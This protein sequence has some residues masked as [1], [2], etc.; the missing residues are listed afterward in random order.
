VKATSCKSRWGR[1][2]P[3]EPALIP[4]SV[5]V[6][7]MGITHMGVGMLQL[8]VEMLMG[9]PER[10]IVGLACHLLLAPMRE[11]PRAPLP[12]QS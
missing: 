11:P 7:V 9:M 2:P 3:A 8:P 12:R 10:L 4:C 1:R 5:A 6:A